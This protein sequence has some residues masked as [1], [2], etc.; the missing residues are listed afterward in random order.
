MRIAVLSDI[1]GNLPAFEAALDHAR[2]HKPDLMVIAGDIIIGSPDSAACWQLA[3]SLGCPILRGNHER[4]AAHFGTP[5]AHPDWTTER[6]T[7]LQWAV[8]QLTAGD[9][10]QMEQLPR[11]LRLP[12][13]P[14]LLIV[15]ASFRDD[16]D[17]I[18]PYTSDAQ[19]EEMFP[20]VQERFIVRG[21][22]HYGQLRLWKDGWIVTAS[23]VGL[24]LDS[25]PTAQYLLLDQTKTGWRIMHQ[26]VPYDL[27]AVIRRFYDT[28]YLE[29]TGTM[30][31]LF[32]REVTTASHHLVPF[33]R[34]YARWQKE[35]DITLRQAEE[36]F[37]NH[38]GSTL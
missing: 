20:G 9:R 11:H 19:L 27:D 13:A 10:R 8:N 17:T 4:Y 34:L 21:H 24:P 5:A 29:A 38:Y 16:H 3:R 14:D 35:G 31:R 6:F 25:S 30:G 22:N 2:Q 12:E 7:P 37:F 26:S 36:R 32:F 1:H 23:S 18:A 15:H 33:L 28:G